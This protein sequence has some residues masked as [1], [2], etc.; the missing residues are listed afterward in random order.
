MRQK[1][2]RPKV[3]TS[4]FRHYQNSHHLLPEVRIFGICY[5][6]RSTI[7]NQHVGERII[8]NVLHPFAEQDIDKGSPLAIIV[9]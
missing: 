6:T 9:V 2:K 8:L 4:D 5:N 1:A 7:V 3:N